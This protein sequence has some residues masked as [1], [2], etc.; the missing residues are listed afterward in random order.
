M[1]VLSPWLPKFMAFWWYSAGMTIL[2]S[3]VRFPVVV[4][5]FLV[6]EVIISNRPEF[7]AAQG[8]AIKNPNKRFFCN[9]RAVKLGNRGL[10]TFKRPSFSRFR[11]DQDQIICSSTSNCVG[12]IK[13]PSLSRFRLD[14]DQIICSSTSNCVGARVYK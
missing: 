6:F 7:C 5:I 4:V 13:R 14:Q 1:K 11:L 12:A 8:S 3:R 2:R 10:K 9:Q